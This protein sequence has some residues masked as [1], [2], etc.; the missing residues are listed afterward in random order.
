MSVV[1]VGKGYAYSLAEKN[2]QGGTVIRGARVIAS[3]QLQIEFGRAGQQAI[4]V[5]ARS[6]AGQLAV[7]TL[8]TRMVMQFE[9]RVQIAT[10]QCADEVAV[11]RAVFELVAIAPQKKHGVIV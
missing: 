11:E 9:Q 7:Q 3:G 10:R 6:I 1:F 2:D 8:V 5:I 4:R